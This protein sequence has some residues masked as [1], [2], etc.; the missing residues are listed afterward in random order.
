MFHFEKCISYKIFHG[1]NVTYPMQIA[2]RL[3]PQLFSTQL[4]FITMIKT[5][6]LG[7]VFNQ[8]HECQGSNRRSQ[9]Y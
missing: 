6:G 7:E 4:D 5:P 2:V 9:R 8:G 3:K 1:P